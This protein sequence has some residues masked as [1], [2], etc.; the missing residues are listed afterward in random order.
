MNWVLKV[1]SRKGREQLGFDKKKEKK[2][3]T[4][5]ATVASSLY[6]LR[7]SFGFLR[8]GKGKQRHE[9]LRDLNKERS[10]KLFFFFSIFF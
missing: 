1:F 5:V 4:F 10:K 6:C 8:I 7:L 3:A 2:N 9:S